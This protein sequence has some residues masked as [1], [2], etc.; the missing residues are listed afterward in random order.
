MNMKILIEI[1]ICITE[2][3]REGHINLRI[4]YPTYPAAK[5]DIR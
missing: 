2:V 4:R 5:F 1:L 3:L